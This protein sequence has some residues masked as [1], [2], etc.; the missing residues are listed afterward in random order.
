MSWPI[1]RDPWFGCHLWQGSVNSN[2]Y[3]THFDKVGPHQAYLVAWERANGPVPDYKEL[4]H[5]C[6]RRLCVNPI[7]FEV[8]SRAENQRRKFWAYR[9]GLKKCQKGHDLH[10]HGRRTP[11]AGLICRICSGV[12][13]KPMPEPE[14]EY[15]SAEDQRIRRLPA[16]G[17]DDPGGNQSP[18]QD[19][20]SEE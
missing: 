7:H 11:E 17:G 20:A 12:W 19:P 10:V 8:V 18:P 14:L 6:R 5:L 4:D 1:E 2:G 15:V 9:S 13:D 3:P 16:D